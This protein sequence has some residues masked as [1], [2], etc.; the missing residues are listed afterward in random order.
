MFFYMM[1]IHWNRVRK[2]VC[3][4]GEIVAIKALPCDCPATT[5][6]SQVISM[7]SCD[8]DLIGFLWQRKQRLICVF[9]ILQQ[10]ERFPHCFP[11]QF[12]V[13]LLSLFNV[14]LGSI[15]KLF[16]Y[17]T[18]LTTELLGQAMIS[19]GILKEPHCEFD[20]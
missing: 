7:C 3:T 11:C 17:L 5:L 4:N 6:V 1:M 15:L 8:K 19:N 2:G 14:K 18:D 12:P 10:H 9:T 13:F 16:F 20:S